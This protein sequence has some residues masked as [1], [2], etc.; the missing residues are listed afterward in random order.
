MNS[1]K[2]GTSSTAI[3]TTTENSQMRLATHANAYPQTLPS[4][5]SNEPGHAE[6]RFVLDEPYARL[7]HAW[8]LASVPERSSSSEPRRVTIN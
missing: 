1:Y 4:S 6:V 8:V 3:V 7:V 2:P 5:T